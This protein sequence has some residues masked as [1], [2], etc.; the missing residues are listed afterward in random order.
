MARAVA[1]LSIGLLTSVA[2]ASP[3]VPR[4]SADLAFFGF[5]SRTVYHAYQLRLFGNGEG[6]LRDLNQLSEQL[7]LEGRG[8]GS[9]GSFDVVSS[10]RYHT[11][12]GTGFHRDT[13][14]SLGIPAVDGRHQAEI[15]SAYLDA[16]ALF[17]RRLDLRLG[18]QLLVDELDWLRL[19]GVR[20]FLHAARWLN[21]VVYAGQPVPF[22]SVLGPDAL[23]FDGTEVSDGAELSLGG[24][25]TADFGAALSAGL[26]FRRT[27]TFR[28]SEIE[29]FGVDDPD[30][31]EITKQ[32]S[33][34]KVG[35]I[36][37]R[38][39]LSVRAAIPGVDVHLSGGVAWDLL[40]GRL[41]S[42]SLRVNYDPAR[43]IHLEAVAE[44]VHPIFLGD[45]IFNVFNVFDTDRV[46]LEGSLEAFEDLWLEA[47][48]S[49]QAFH[50]GPKGSLSDSNL[51]GA[52]FELDASG[53]SHV[54][55]GSIAYDG[56]RFGGGVSVEAATNTG[57]RYAYGGNYRLLEIFL[58]AQV[59]EELS[60]GARITLTG[61]QDDWYEDV[62]A[63]AVQREERSTTVALN[64]GARIDTVF[65]AKLDLARTFGSV[66]D[67]NYR[68]T[69]LVEVTP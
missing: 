40:F 4:E 60:A 54:P 62:D 8:L 46:R 33:A 50:G 9:E 61:F 42:A 10:L 5:S 45:S 17:D 47:S 23:G 53:L 13:A 20:A 37:Q 56:S 65:R 39:G 3:I 21:V 27:L 6:P 36:E 51:G 58:R 38:L 16:R 41:E 52:G 24:S 19:D 12:F 48:W 18:R 43:S 29:V 15:L 31:A 67:G 57:G 14:V 32:S 69:T 34:R 25:V 66:L 68:V 59:F 55:R 63:G 35:L 26:A 2:E 30:L 28:G 44:R 7:D 49:L 11:D 1:W 64:L 22:D